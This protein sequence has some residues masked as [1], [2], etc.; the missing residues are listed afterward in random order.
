MRF[1]FYIFVYLIWII[2]L[3]SQQP[4]RIQ[5][6]I[7]T[8]PQNNPRSVSRPLSSN[9]NAI[10]AI[11]PSSIHTSRN[12]RITFSNIFGGPPAPIQG[13]EILAGTNWT[14]ELLIGTNRI[15]KAP[16]LSVG[17]KVNGIFNAGA[18]DIPGNQG[19]P[20]EMTIRV[21]QTEHLDCEKHGYFVATF[22]HT[23][24]PASV[25]PRI[26][27]GLAGSINAGGGWEYFTPKKPA[28]PALFSIYGMVVLVLVAAGILLYRAK[29]K[30]KVHPSF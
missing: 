30:N 6:P 29:S 14:A 21:Y 16:L 23:P 25:S 15:F 22:N 26:P 19:Q 9:V 11:P 27:E 13:T 3:H 2:D 24:T 20:V 28:D 8:Q 12:A 1:I 10:P 4:P 18:V 7:A 17:G 5:W